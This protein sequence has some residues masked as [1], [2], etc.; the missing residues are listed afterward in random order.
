MLPI[1]LN[2]E[3]LRVGL[4]GSG[5]AFQRRLSFLVE[6][7]VNSPVL[8]PSGVPASKEISALNILFVARLEEPEARALSSLARALGV[9]VN[10]EDKPELCDF[11][12]PAL[13]RR[14]DLLLTIST[15][16]RSPG[17]ARILREDLEKHF[18]PEWEARLD[19][20]AAARDAWRASGLAAHDVSERT[21]ALVDAKGWRP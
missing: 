9:L 10:V 6:A 11:H 5:D 12:V 4:A 19:E 1:V 2:P 14:G 18:G 3:F 17:V 16:G 13:V 8:F 15:G 20:I 21:S 7:G